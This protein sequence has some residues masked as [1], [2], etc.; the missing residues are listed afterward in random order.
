MVKSGSA[1]I[2]KL[3]TSQL[4]FRLHMQLPLFLELP[5]ISC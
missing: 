1:L 3:S 5:T 4:L 2:N